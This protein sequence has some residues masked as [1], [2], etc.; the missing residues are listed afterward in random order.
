[1]Y[2]F[3]IQRFAGLW[4]LTGFLAVQASQAR[5]LLGFIAEIQGS[6]HSA[7]RASVEM[8]FVGRLQE[9]E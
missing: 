2:F 6:L 9:K 1:L 7:P 8:T 4:G 3:W 5:V